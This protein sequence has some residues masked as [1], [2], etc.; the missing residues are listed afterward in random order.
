MSMN[1]RRWLTATG[2]E[3]ESANPDQDASHAS[4][5]QKRKDLLIAAGINEI[6]AE[7]VAAE[8]TAHA[9]ANG[10]NAGQPGTVQHDLEQDGAGMYGT[11]IGSR[12]ASA[13]KINTA[14]ALAAAGTP[15]DATSAYSPASRPGAHRYLS[16]RGSQQQAAGQLSDSPAMLTGHEAYGA[17]A[18]DEKHT[19]GQIVDERKI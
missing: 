12:N 2:L 18:V 4:K 8:L 1:R 15:G 9:A 17:V 5:V 11:R 10:N 19:L 6:D 13:T 7:Q 3:Y 16:R 14:G